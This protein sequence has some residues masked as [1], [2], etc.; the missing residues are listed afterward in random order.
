MTSQYEKEALRYAARGIPVFPLAAGTKVPTKNS[1][2]HLDASKNEF[3]LR[4]Y[5]EDEPRGNVGMPT[6][7]KSGLIIIDEDPRKGGDASSLNLPPTLTVSTPQGGRHF[8]FKHPGAGLKVPCDT[9]GKLGPGIDV[10]GEGG[11]A[12]L[13]PSRLSAGGKYAWVNAAVPPAD[14]P[15]HLWPTLVVKDD[16]E[17]HNGV[18]PTPAEDAEPIRDGQRN[19]TLASLAG[20][21]RKRGTLANCWPC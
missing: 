2:G 8:Y 9:T 13:P 19:T 7:V 6:G 14:I 3:V 10:K 18:H 5:W 16:P 15:P 21:M 4:V 11:Y 12:V 20:T 1:H 17:H